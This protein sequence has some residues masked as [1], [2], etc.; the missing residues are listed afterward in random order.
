MVS[1]LPLDA[2]RKPVQL[3]P[4]LAALE[5]DYDPTISSTAEYTF[6]ATATMIEVVAGGEAVMM[7]WGTTDAS[8]T[9][10]DHIILEGT[11]RNFVIPVDLSTPGVIYTAVNFIER[12]AT[13]FVGISQFAG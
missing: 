10:W 8:T 11:T 5:E 6:E 3:V 12:A 2:S 13:A 9:D 1:N 4:A 7:K